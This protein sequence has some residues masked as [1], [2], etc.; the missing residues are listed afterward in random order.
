MD[1]TATTEDDVGKAA[2]ATYDL[3]A[4]ELYLNRELS[5][6]Q[7]NR[8]VLHEAQDARTPLLER[9]KFLAIV[10]SNLDEFFMKRIAVLRDRPTPERALLMKEIR[11]RLLPMP[12]GCSCKSRSVTLAVQRMKIEVFGDLLEGDVVVR[13]GNDEIRPGT[14]ITPQPRA[15]AREGT[16]A[17]LAR[18]FIR[19]PAMNPAPRVRRADAAL[20][21]RE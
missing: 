2:I 17:W 14:R 4:L 18:L 9:V 1:S 21:L 8:R 12:C 13:R 11:A 20:L 7:F 15:D 5:W 16:G 10:N 3:R 6:L 19:N